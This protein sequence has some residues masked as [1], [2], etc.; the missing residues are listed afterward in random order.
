MKLYGKSYVTA[1]SL[2]AGLGGFLF[3]FDTAVISGAVNF[4]RVQFHLDAISE[5]WLMSSALAGCVAGAAVSGYL[6]DK[7]GRKKILLASAI[8]FI[9]SALACAV[10]TTA[11]YLV[12]ARIIG[13]IG[14]GF[15]A[16]VAPMFISELSPAKMRGRLVSLYQLAITLG[17]L[18]SYLTNAALLQYAGSNAL[19][20]GSFM[21]F[22]MVQEVWR[23]M[24]GSNI[25][26]A[27]LF[28]ILLL[29]VPESPRWL[30]KEN[31]TDAAK[32]VLE[33]I[34]GDENGTTELNDIQKTIVQEKGSFRQLLEPGMRVAL[35]IGIVLPLLTQFTGITTVMYYAPAIFE[36][37]GFGTNSAMSGAALIGFFNMFFTILA[38]WKIDKWGRKPLLVWGFIGLS[39]ALFLI[40]I[41]F[42]NA[43]AN[44]SLLLIAFVFYIAVFA[45]TLGPGVWV[46]LS[47][48]YPT[49]IRGRAMS[50]GTLSLF[51][52]STFVTQTYPWLRESTGISFTFIMYGLVM[53]PAAFFV[54]K[55]VPETKGKTLEEIER[56][57]KKK[58]K[59]KAVTLVPV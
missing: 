11:S 53:L 37:A 38:I 43:V 13:G 45:A 10:A 12:I 57:W 50:V 44:T 18:V 48:I 19:N 35:I 25:I 4:L 39:I 32:T 24:L 59:E 41:L 30:V 22:Y 58:E 54:R 1:I 55:M 9:I 27:I 33:R 49:R 26:P 17:I 23:A 2:S 31:K 51:L 42:G 52:G 56:H 46:V 7:F 16:M 47:E 3:G 20:A 36:K 8:L 40:G 14:V 29:F 21:H 28:F 15:A 5:G 34:N 6:A